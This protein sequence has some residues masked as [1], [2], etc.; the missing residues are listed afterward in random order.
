MTNVDSDT[1][2]PLRETMAFSAAIVPMM[3]VGRLQTICAAHG[4]GHDS[5]VLAAVAIYLFVRFGVT[6][7]IR[8][9]TVHRGMFHSIP[10]MFIF[11]GI[12][13]LL[14]GGS[15]FDVRCYKAGGVMGGFMSHL[16]L[17]EI[18]AMLR[19]DLRMLA[20]EL[21]IGPALA[22]C[23]QRI[24]CRIFQDMTVP[25]IVEKVFADHGAIASYELNLFGS[26]RKRVYCVQYR[27][28]DYQFVARLLEEEGIYWFFAHGENSHKLMLVDDIGALAPAPTPA[29][30]SQARSSVSLRTASVSDS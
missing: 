26:Y 10:A 3:L 7:I 8:K 25:E 15:P 29:A 21:E 13:F 17:D 18:Y 23:M 1:G 22:T 28:S 14:C 30:P 24:D 27:E 16:I 19:G 2:V 12:A 11:V 5:I 9:C 20:V 6:N 4:L